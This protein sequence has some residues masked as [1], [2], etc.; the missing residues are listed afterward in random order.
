MTPVTHGIAWV[1]FRG[2]ELE[3]G[4]PDFSAAEASVCKEERWLIG[5]DRRAWDG[6][7]EL[8]WSGGCV[9]VG[10]S[11]AFWERRAFRRIGRGYAPLKDKWAKWHRGAMDVVKR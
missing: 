5:R 1:S 4:K 3:I 8:K 2:E 7:E 6:R 9:D 10:P 11:Y